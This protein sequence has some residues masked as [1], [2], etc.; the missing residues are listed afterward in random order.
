MNDGGG[1]L[2]TSLPP[3]ILLNQSLCATDKLPSA[4]WKD[5]ASIVTRVMRS[6][7]GDPL[8]ELAECPVLW[9]DVQVVA[10]D[11]RRDPREH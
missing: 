3:T 8:V 7:A 11:N 5:A 10:K 4:P 1:I 2:N 9:L 6:V